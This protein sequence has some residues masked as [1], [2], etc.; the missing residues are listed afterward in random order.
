MPPE[1]LQSLGMSLSG[2]SLRQS[3]WL[4]VER[5]EPVVASTAEQNCASEQPTPSTAAAGSLPGQE[6]LGSRIPSASA[7]ASAAAS[8]ACAFTS[9]ACASARSACA[10]LA[11]DSA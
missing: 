8:A 4:Q 6:S 5:P 11:A 7:S 9:C 1:A 2:S 3:E 10:A